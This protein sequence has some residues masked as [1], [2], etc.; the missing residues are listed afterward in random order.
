MREK[1]TT[2]PEG[3]L[4]DLIDGQQLN[5]EPE[6]PPGLHYRR[7]RS[8]LGTQHNNKR[9]R[10]RG[11]PSL[12]KI[13]H[14]AVQNTLD[15]VE[16][17]WQELE[18]F[19]TGLNKITAKK[20]MADLSPA[21]MQARTVLRQLMNHWRCGRLQDRRVIRGRAGVVRACCGVRACGHDVLAYLVIYSEGGGAWLDGE[22]GE[23]E[24]EGG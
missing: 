2:Q 16:R 5:R 17:L 20:F 6:E 18:V 10:Q 3:A 4:T 22:G 21:H 7:A 11:R 15:H 24:E 14:R 8:H 13:Y 19:E 1:R 12:R 9:C 23:E